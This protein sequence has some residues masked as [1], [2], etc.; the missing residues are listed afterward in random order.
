[1]WDTIDDRLYKIR[2][3][4]NIAGTVQQLPLFAPPISPALL[5]QAEAMGVDL[6]SV[7]N[8]INAVVPNFRCTFMLQKAL[9]LCGEVRALGAA[10]LAA[11]EKGEAEHLA[12]L[13]ATQET[14]CS[15][16]RATPSSISSTRPTPP[17]MYCRT[18]RA[19]SPRRSTTTIRASS[20]LT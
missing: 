12:L 19:P 16:R 6:S 14:S 1:Y 9:D 13:R 2:H 17:S 7:L 3:C 5:V 11:H 4:M 20:P 10:F 8:D 15:K 18:A